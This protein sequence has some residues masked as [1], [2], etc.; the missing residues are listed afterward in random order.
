[1]VGND[2]DVGV[3]YNA[4]WR[5]RKGRASWVV[6]TKKTNVSLERVKCKARCKKGGK[7]IQPRKTEAP[8]PNHI[9]VYGPLLSSELAREGTRLNGNELLRS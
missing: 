1:M 7:Q 5:N 9:G 8:L 4:C 3:E 2:A 6:T